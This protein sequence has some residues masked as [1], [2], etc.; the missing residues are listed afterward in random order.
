[1]VRKLMIVN[2]LNVNGMIKQMYLLR[3]KV[4]S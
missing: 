3:L 1:M 4:F 2:Q